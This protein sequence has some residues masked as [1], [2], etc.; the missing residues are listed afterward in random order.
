MRSRPGSVFSWLLSAFLILPNIGYL[1]LAPAAYGDWAIALKGTNEIILLSLAVAGAGLY[2][3]ATGMLFRQ[4]NSTLAAAVPAAIH[5]GRRLAWGA[6]AIANVLAAGAA[7]RQ[8][9]AGSA[10]ALSGWP[11]AVASL[12]GTSGLVWGVVALRRARVGQAPPLLPLRLRWPIV[13]AAITVAAA[14]VGILGR[15]VHFSR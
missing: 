1:C 11:G 15:G 12:A 2:W 6:Y 3:G 7:A 14:F 9:G 8:A 4:F 10:L 13:V 5:R